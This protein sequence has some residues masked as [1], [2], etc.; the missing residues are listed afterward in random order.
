VVFEEVALQT[1][2]L[3]LL[4]KA[5][6]EYAMA[7]GLSSH[8]VVI[9]VRGELKISPMICRRWSPSLVASAAE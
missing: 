8:M 2:V 3:G 5:F 7:L 1:D 4:A 6:W 9:S